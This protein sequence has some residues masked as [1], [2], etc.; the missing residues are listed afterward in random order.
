LF[1]FTDYSDSLNL[2]RGNPALKPEFTNSLELSYSKTMKKGHSILVSAY[3]KY[4]TDLITRSQVAEPHPGKPGDT[5]LINTYINANNSNVGGIEF[6]SRNPITKWWETT[7]N[8]N[9]FTS[10]INLDQPGLI[11]QDRIYSWF[12]KM[13][14]TFKMP[15]NFTLQVT[16]DYTSKTILPPGGSGGSGGGGGGGG[17]RPGGGGGGFFGQPQSTAQGYIRPTYGVDA[18]L[19]YEFLKNKTASVSLSVNDILKTRRSDTY[20]ESQ[21]F[22]QNSYRVRDQQV[23]RLNFNYRFGKIDM[24]LFKRKNMKAGMDG[25]QEGMQQQ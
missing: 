12:A 1:P 13:S 8:L 15:K 10:K 9:L 2:S 25:V 4:T 7:T 16:G 14:W 18:A 23:F 3:Y 20:S 6:T 17:G 5:I 22:I 19:R 11:P 21:Y 24:S